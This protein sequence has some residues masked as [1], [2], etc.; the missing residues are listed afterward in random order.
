MDIT[1]RCVVPEMEEVEP[2][3]LTYQTAQGRYVGSVVTDYNE[4][5]TPNNGHLEALGAQRVVAIYLDEIQITG[6]TDVPVSAQADVAIGDTGRVE[7]GADRQPSCY[8]IV[9]NFS[10]QVVHSVSCCKT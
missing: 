10:G 4:T 3:Q 2:V 5:P 9:R 1:V 6:E 7:L 8:W